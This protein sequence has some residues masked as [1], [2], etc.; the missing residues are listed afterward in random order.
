VIV[1]VAVAAR[2]F[3]GCSV[4]AAGAA[5]RVATAIVTA[6]V[7]AIVTA[8]VA[9]IVAVVFFISELPKLAQALVEVGS[10]NI[11]HRAAHRRIASA[12]RE[13]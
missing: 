12:C 11:H 10:G 3:V 6:I 1:I 4:G 5:T 7:A 13:W 2:S 9:A 8:I